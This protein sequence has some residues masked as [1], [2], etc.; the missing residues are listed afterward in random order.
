MKA[1]TKILL[2]PFVAFA[3][4]FVAAVFYSSNFTP[5]RMVTGEATIISFVKFYRVA[6]PLL[7]ADVILIQLLM[8]LP[9]WDGIHIGSWV[10]KTIAAVDLLFICLLIALGIS[11]AIWD[12]PTGAARFDKIF[13]FIT[14]VQVVYWAINLFILYLLE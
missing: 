1:L 13:V 7:F 4:F 14:S 11:Y 9:V 8:I 12:P 2:P 10:L 5:V 6:L 3:V